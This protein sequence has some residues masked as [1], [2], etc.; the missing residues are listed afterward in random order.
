MDL[1]KSSSLGWFQSPF[2][3]KT[4]VQFS[5]VRILNTNQQQWHD[6]AETARPWPNQHESEGATTTSQDPGE[7]FCCASPNK[8][9]ISKYKMW[10]QHGVAKLAVQACSHC[11]LSSIY[12]FS[13]HLMSSHGS[14]LSKTQCESVLAKHHVSLYHMTYPKTSTWENYSRLV[15]VIGN[16]DRNHEELQIISTDRSISQA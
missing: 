16:N 14:C 7:V 9:K 15:A 3:R 10:D 8:A 2:V 13:K 4:A 5:S 6:P 12:T 1:F 11:L